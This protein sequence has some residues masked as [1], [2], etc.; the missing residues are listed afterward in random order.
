[1]VL[2]GPIHV[3]FQGTLLARATWSKVSSAHDQPAPAER[4]IGV[5]SSVTTGTRK[6][7]VELAAEPGETIPPRTLPSLASN[8]ASV[9]TAAASETLRSP[10][11]VLIVDDD[12]DAREIY[13]EYLRFAGYRTEVAENGSRA[14]ERA[15][16]RRPDLVLLDHEMPVMSG[17]EA[18]RLLRTDP[19]T[20]DIPIVMLTALPRAAL[21]SEPDWD[22][23]FRKPCHPEKVLDAIES[24]LH[25]PRASRDGGGPIG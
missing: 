3:T 9:P 21:S 12:A 18:A 24:L 22:H 2:T 14:V 6:R 13:D 8:P 5:R 19:R 1:M 4:E 10:P 7:P 16:E 23:Y 11:L 20:R 17:A 25:A 15:M